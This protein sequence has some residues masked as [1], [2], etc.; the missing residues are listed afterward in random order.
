MKTF[1]FKIHDNNYRVNLIAHN[2]NVIDLEVNGTNYQVTL[3]TEVKKTKT[4]TLVRA[5]SKRPIEPLKV[6]PAA[7]KTKILAPIPGVIL[8]VD[9]KVGD[10]V[11]KGDRLVLLEA[12]KMENNIVAEKEGTVTAVHVVKDQKVLEKELMIEMD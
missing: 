12:M 8:G 9:V 2:K 3:E 5:A 11:K 6:S 1:K 10:T 4:P 7:K